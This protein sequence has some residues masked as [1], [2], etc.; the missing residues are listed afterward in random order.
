MVTLA[1]C[2]SAAEPAP[3]PA[4]ESPAQEPP[5]QA[6]AQRSAA[7]QAEPVLITDRSQREAAV[8]KRVT[9]VGVQS[10]TKMPQ[11]NGVDVDGDHELSG[12][13]VRVDGILRKHVVE[14][15]EPDPDEL[16]IATR[17]PG[18]YYSVVDPET[19]RLARP[20]PE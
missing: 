19:G 2:Q 20:R 16:P 5:V 1:A 9:V 18:T 10:P 7:P 17:G 8:G 12:R 11:V 3:P 6:A 15:S 14:P 4:T 13:Q